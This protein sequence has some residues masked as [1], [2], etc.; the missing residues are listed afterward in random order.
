MGNV[1]A[2]TR[3]STVKQGEKGVSLQEQKDAIL[4]YAQQHGLEIVRWF[5]EC[6]SAAKTGRPAFMQMLQL[7]RIKVAQGVVIHKIDRSARN[8]EDWADVSKLADAGVAIHFANEGVDL[9]TVSGR[10]SADIQAVVASH[11]SRNLREEAKKGI[12]G[13]LKQGFYPFRA[14][15]GYTDQGAA[16]LKLPD[17]AMAPLVQETFELYGAGTFPLME[18]ADHMYERGLRNRHGGPVTLKGISTILNNPFYIGVLRIKK[19]GQD[20][21]GNHVPLVNRDLFERVQ[22]LL[23]GKTVDR[24]VRHSFL[25][26][27]LV[28]CAS[29]HYSLIGERRKGHTYYRCHNRPFKSPPVCPRTFIKEEQLEDAVQTILEKLTLSKAEV[30]YFREWIADYRLNAGAKREEEKRVAT[31]QLEA[32]RARK[33]RLTDLLLDRSVEQATFDEKQKS[34]VWEESQLKQKVARLDAGCDDALKKME[35]TVGLAK[36]ASLLYKQASLE[37]KRELLRILLSDLTASRENI[38]AELINP[39]SV[40]AERSKT[41]CGGPYRRT[42]RTMDN[43]MNQI[44]EHILKA[45]SVAWK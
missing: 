7:L 29:C 2:Y 24:A 43:I 32:L 41:S 35:N 8:L 37:R 40:I 27:R 42:C 13:R 11:Y 4:R 15:I 20:F 12:Y 1:F 21:S 38:S 36:E 10:L 28:R 45:G 34:L 18:L 25:F 39:F 30:T 22:A 31:L 26:S 33:S 9:A 6:E 14:P 5:E 44:L 17:P 19:T 16:K 23:R 3:V